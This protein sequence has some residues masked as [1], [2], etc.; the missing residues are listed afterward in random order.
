MQLIGK[1]IVLNDE[2]VCEFAM[3]FSITIMRVE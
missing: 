1:R 2:S 3:A